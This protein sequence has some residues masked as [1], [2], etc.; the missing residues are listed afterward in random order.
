MPDVQRFHHTT[1]NLT[2]SILLF[3]RSHTRIGRIMAHFRWRR[4]YRKSIQ[5]YI[6]ENGVPDLVHVHIPMKA[7]I[8]AL[9][10]KRKFKV[11]FVVTEHWGIYNETEKLNYEGR[12]S[13]FKQLTKRIFSAAAAFTSVSHF[14][15]QGVNRLVLKKDYFIIPNVVD[16]QRFQMGPSPVKTHFT[17]LHVSNMVPLKNTAGI[18]RA[19][20]LVLSTGVDA[21]LVMVGN[22]EDSAEDLAQY[23]K[24]PEG[25]VQ[26]RGEIHY[27][28]VAKEM[29][30][31]DCFV[32]FSDIEN[33][34][35]VISESHCSGLPVIATE[36]GG[37]PEMVNVNNGLLVKPRDENGLAQAML[38][39]IQTIGRYDKKA[40][41]AEAQKRYSYE[42]VGKQFEDLYL[43]VLGSSSK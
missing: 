30:Q 24:F 17:F 4:H 7:G 29:Q 27:E 16:T 22:R 36:T 37:I 38:D 5:D 14:L 20:Q 25:R 8:M 31:A 23:M 6:S 2:E 32:L 15:A 3:R 39:M 21:V 35:C 28:D 33:A 1:G 42:T 40:I 13:V 9:W 18:L 19:F 41:A 26:F 12:S 34:P 11:P 43:S 10:M